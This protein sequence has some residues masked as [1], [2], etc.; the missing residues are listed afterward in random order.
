LVTFFAAVKSNWHVGP[1]PTV[2]I[3]NPSKQTQNLRLQLDV[4]QYTPDELDLKTIKI[5]MKIKNVRI[6]SNIA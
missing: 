2:L 5:E 6:L 3:E 1:L 4:S